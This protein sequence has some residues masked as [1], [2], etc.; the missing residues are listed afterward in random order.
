M[1]AIISLR[2][3]DDNRILKQI[4]V[5]GIPPSTKPLYEPGE[6]NVRIDGVDT[7]VREILLF[8]VEK[9]KE[10]TIIRWELT[11]DTDTCE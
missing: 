11:K 7:F 3:G 4:A 8:L 5:S 9:L 2:L 1:E 10:G 6:V